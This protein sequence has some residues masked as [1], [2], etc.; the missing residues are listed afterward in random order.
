[1]LKKS[2]LALLLVVF[3]NQLALAGPVHKLGANAAFQLIQQNPSIFLLDVRTTQE[4]QQYRLAGATLIPLGD[5][6][7][8]ERELPEGRPILVYCEVGHRSAQVADYLARRSFDEVYDLQ[9]GI[10]GWQLRKLPVLKGLP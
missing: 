5:L 1:M 2:L 7:A 10:W 8:R 9:G 6:L 4:Y 3:G